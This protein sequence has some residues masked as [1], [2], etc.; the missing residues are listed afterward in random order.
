MA[1][2]P[3]SLTFS[4]ASLLIGQALVGVAEKTISKPN[5]V[6]FLTDDQDQVLGASFPLTSGATPMPKTK[7][8]MQDEGM[9]AENWY[10][11]TPICSPSRSELL[12]GRY[13][14]NIKMTGPTTMHVNY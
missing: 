8:L 11:H 5:I 7:K 4:V 13:F 2:V 9:Y 1:L 10:I 6:W 14:H 3:C 12:T